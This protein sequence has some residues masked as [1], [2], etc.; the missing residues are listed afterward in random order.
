MAPPINGTATCDESDSYHFR[1]LWD[2][3]NRPVY[4]R[5]KFSASKLVPARLLAQDVDQKASTRHVVPSCD[6][7]PPLKAIPLAN[8]YKVHR[9]PDTSIPIM[10]DLGQNRVATIDLPAREPSDPMLGAEPAPPALPNGV[11]NKLLEQVIR[12]PDRF[13]SPQPT[14]LGAPGQSPHRIL[15]EE[16]PGYE[17]PKFDGKDMQ[18]DQGKYLD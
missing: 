11:H 9:I 13:P 10:A 7:W 2:A 6:S 15:H 5:Q 12:T 17:A 18:M 1:P 8:Y 4:H 16:G 14:H 3:S